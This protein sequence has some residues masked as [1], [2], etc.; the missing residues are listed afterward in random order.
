[1]P[2]LL[3]AEA[4]CPKCGAPLEPGAAFC[5]RCGFRLTTAAA[6][7]PTPAATDGRASVVQLITVHDNEL[8]ST[9][10]SIVF[11]SNRKV[12]SI[13]GNAFPVAPGE[14][15]TEAALL[16]G[17]KQIT[18]RTAGGA[19]VPARLVGVDAMVGVALLK[20]DLPDLAPLP[21]RTDTPP[22]LGES[23]RALGFSSGSGST[24]DAIVS[25][26][27]VSGL[28]RRALHLHPVDDNIQ[29]DASIPR[30]FAGGPMLDSRGAV[31]GMS[32]GLVYGSQVALG[33]QT[34]IGFAI[35]SEWIGRA[36]A[37]IR[38]GSPQRGWIGAYTVPADA[39]RRARFKLPGEV[40]AIIDQVFPGSPAE[41][42]GLKRG[43]G[44]L[45]ALGEEAT[46]IPR[47]QERF[48]ALKP[49][50]TVSLE[51]S[52][53]GENRTLSLALVPRP[54][55]PRLS[56]VD[57]LRYFGD[58]DLAAR[59]DSLVVATVTP[60]SILTH[61][62]IAPG[63]L[64]QSVLSKKDWV[65]GAKDNSRWR[66]VRTTADLQER[67][68]T[69]YSDLDFYLGLRFRSKDGAKHEIFLWEILTPTGAL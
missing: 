6:P 36:L 68:E 38:S 25:S 52:R 65:H 35:P 9:Y 8:T 53:A 39:E 16:V 17:A 49:G 34:G 67:L 32:T 54:E 26:G 46:S 62:K 55:K 24:R 48:L 4:V 3:A 31:V 22:A 63:D 20:A 28:H 33:L 57:A 64:L 58:I 1:V 41:A 15:I 44:L 21:L 45:K 2:P 69:A 14:F 30:G 12:D 23:V 18:L 56:G 59:D 27:V 29:T 11:E 13:L 50:D 19:S 5:V 61:F 60:G 43:D 10:D 47:L 66:S 40:H 51:T 37:W 7:P 42:A